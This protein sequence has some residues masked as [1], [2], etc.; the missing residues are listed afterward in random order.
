ML[1][2][3]M[4]CLY[5]YTVSKRKVAV[6]CGSLELAKDLGSRIPDK[7]ND[8]FV[9]TQNPDDFPTFWDDSIPSRTEGGNFS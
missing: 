1:I 3:K 5:Y 2:F 9:V 7:I 4:Y 8:F 6:D